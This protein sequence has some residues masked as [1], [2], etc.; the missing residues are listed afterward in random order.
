MKFIVFLRIIAITLIMGG[1]SIIVPLNYFWLQSKVAVAE[2]TGTVPTSNWRPNPSPTVVSGQPIG[3]SIPSLNINLQ[4]I[5]GV[6]NSN[7]GAW[8]LSLDK[9]QF[10]E[11]S[12]P[13]KNK[14]G[15]TFIYGHYRREVFASLHLIQPGAKAIISTSNGY[16]F[17]YTY[18]NTEA[19]DPTDTSVFTY[20]GPPRL[21]VQTCSGSLFQHRQMYYFQYDGFVKTSVS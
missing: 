14:S 13:P 6:Y 1:L 21:T 2:H 15:K 10:A 16:N 4:V 18:L 8:T 20:N 3:I 17:S 9:A 12:A 19:T 5:P 7:T 11:I